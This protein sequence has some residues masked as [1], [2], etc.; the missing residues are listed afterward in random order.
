MSTVII[1]AVP[2]GLPMMVALVLSSNMKR[3]LKNNVMVRKMVGIETAG[4]LNILFTDKTGTITSGK[5]NVSKL[6]NYK[7]LECTNKKYIDIFKKSILYNNQSEYS[8]G[9][10][11]G[12]NTTDQA[13]MRYLKLI[14]EEDYEHVVLFNSKNKY[15][16][17]KMVNS[18]MYYFKGANEVII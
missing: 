10:A 13:I 4:S 9:N 5:L 3:M 14:K 17:T 12:G 15:S 11:V 16:V 2:E 8:N 6:I 1:V 7:G 18:N